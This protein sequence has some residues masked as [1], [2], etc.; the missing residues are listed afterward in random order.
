MKGENLP[1]SFWIEACTQQST[2][3]TEHQPGREENKRRKELGAQKGN[4]SFD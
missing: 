4:Q 2:S 3:L 1:N